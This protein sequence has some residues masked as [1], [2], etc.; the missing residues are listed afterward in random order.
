VVGLALGVNHSLA[1]TTEGKVYSWGCGDAGRLGHGKGTK[2]F[3]KL[4]EPLM[5]QSLSSKKVI[6]AAAG[7]EHTLILTGN[8]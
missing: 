6:D 5:I 2:K 1:W 4:V 7:T 8:T 3:T